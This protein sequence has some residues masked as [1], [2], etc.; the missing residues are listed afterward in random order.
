MFKKNS[1]LF[2]LGIAMAV[3][4]VIILFPPKLIFDYD[5]ESFFP[6]DDNELFFYQEFRENFEND[7]DYLLIALGRNPDIFDSGFLDQSMTFV[8][9][10]NQLEDVIQVISLLDIEDQIISPFGI[11]GSK[12]L[13]WDSKEDLNKSLAKINQSDQWIGNLINK[14]SR[15]LLVIVK[16][17]QN[18]SKEDG[19]ILYN[20]I[21]TLIADSDIGE[22]YSAGKIKAQ[23]EFVRLL[24]DEFSFFI[25]FSILLVVFVLYLI[26]RTWWGIMI[27]LVVLAIGIIW[28]LS[29]SLYTGKAL[30][31]MSV[32]QPTVLSVIGLA[33]MVHFF[34][35]FINLSREGLNRQ[36][37]V[38]K[39]FSELGF[40]VFL[41]C[42]T[43]SLGFLSLYT[44]SIPSLKYFGLYTGLGVMLMFF[45]VITVA[46]GLLYL[47]PP[48][49]FNSKTTN[50]DRWRVGM[51]TVFIWILGHQRI[52]VYSFMAVSVMFVYVGSKVQINGYILDNLPR[53]HE[54]MEEF[55]LFDREFRGSKPLEFYLE[56]GE[57]GRSLLELEVLEEMDKLETFIIDNYESAPIISPLT[58]VKKLNQAQNSGNPKAFTLPS[59]GQLFRMKDFIPVAVEM[60]HSKVLSDD[61]T[62]GR[63]STRTE[64]FGSKKSQL[65]NLKLNDFLE[66]EIDQD[67]LKV[68]LTGT[69]HLIDISHESVTWQMVKGLG[70]AL[71][72]VAVIMGFLFKSWRISTLVLVPNIIPLLWMLGVMG[73]LNIEMKLT[74]AILFTVAFGIAVDDSIHFMSKLKIELAKGKSWI[75]ALKRTFLETGKAIILTTAIL[76]SGFSILIFSQFGVTYFSGLLISISLIF[77]L[78]SDLILFP[79]LLIQLNITRKEKRDQSSDS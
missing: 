5:F 29:F 50:E 2:L 34:N 77:A 7:N 47:F 65:L 61:F 37:A 66:K 28:I 43:T 71:I 75:Y 73:F 72:I 53:G 57:K 20:S 26:F 58:I 60:L 22:V 31:V 4:L 18:I 16:N 41:T 62:Q 52:V 67:L 48:P 59:Q 17:R 70:L 6:Q 38:Q 8:N 44:T 35:H 19:D 54:L 27:P 23:G 9:A 10:L 30:D 79:V 15:Y 33:A 24:Q 64:D 78:L 32:M 69:S 3:T 76:V 74:T 13:N 68:K 12:V 1:S 46:P 40:A 55:R 39:A 63:I 21:Q 14:D 42:L 45:A 51:R 56:T 49:N 11:S 25:S 36:Q